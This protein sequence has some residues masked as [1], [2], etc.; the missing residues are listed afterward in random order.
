MV[1]PLQA[2]GPCVRFPLIVLSSEGLVL[3]LPLETELNQDDADERHAVIG[4]GE[5]PSFL[6]PR[7]IPVT[8]Q[9][10]KAE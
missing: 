1:E 8:M 4:L 7:T 2:G 10:G 9:V 6:W 5:G 3:P